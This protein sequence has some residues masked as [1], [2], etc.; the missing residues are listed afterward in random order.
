M[1]GG[2]TGSPLVPGK[3]DE[4]PL[5]LQI[6]SRAKPKMPPKKDLQPDE[7]AVLRAW[8]AAGAPYSK[9]A[10]PSLDEKVPALAQ[11]AHVLPQVTSLAWRPDGQQLAIA[12]YKRCAGWQCLA[13]PAQRR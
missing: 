7:I 4:S 9:A 2:D 11:T 8:V 10:R 6:E 3:P 5:I 12:G 13:A 1:R